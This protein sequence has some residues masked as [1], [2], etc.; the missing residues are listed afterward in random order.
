MLIPDGYYKWSSGTRIFY[1]SDK[2]NKKFAGMLK[3]VAK[4]VSFINSPDIFPSLSEG[5]IR[6]KIPNLL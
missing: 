3:L 2:E 4:E 1:N 5:Y 6:I